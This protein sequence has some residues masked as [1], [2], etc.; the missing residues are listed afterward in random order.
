[1]V[2]SK[3]QAERPDCCSSEQTQNCRDVQVRLGVRILAL[4]LT[5]KVILVM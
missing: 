5:S 3:S 4:P 1:M 2:V